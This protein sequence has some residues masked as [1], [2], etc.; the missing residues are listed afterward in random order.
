[1]KCATG[2]TTLTITSS[3]FTTAVYGPI[4]EDPRADLKAKVD[5]AAITFSG[6]VSDNGYGIFVELHPGDIHPSFGVFVKP[7]K[8]TSL[9]DVSKAVAQAITTFKPDLTRGN[10]TASQSGT[11][12]TVNNVRVVECKISRDIRVGQPDNSFCSVLS[13]CRAIALE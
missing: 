12:V 9:E 13:P 5:G 1:M 4:A 10:V 6:E 7:A 11:T 8:N 2:T 3:D